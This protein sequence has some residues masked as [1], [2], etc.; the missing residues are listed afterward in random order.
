MG[1]VGTIE[2]PRGWQGGAAATLGQP[3]GGIHARGFRMT[4]VGGHAK[5]VFADCVFGTICRA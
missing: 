2:S 4:A 3:N 1:H 5:G